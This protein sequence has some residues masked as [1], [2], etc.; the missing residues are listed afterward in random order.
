LQNPDDLIADGQT[1]R[2][3]T[4]PAGQ[5]VLTLP[6][7]TASAD[8]TSELLEKFK[9]EIIATA[10]Y[11]TTNNGDVDLKDKV[12][13]LDGWHKIEP[14]I[15]DNITL[16]GP[17]NNVSF[18]ND[19]PLE[20]VDINDIAQGECGDCYFLA[21]IGAMALKMPE[22]IRNDI[23]EIIPDGTL[24]VS[25]FPTLNG[26]ATDVIIPMTLDNGWAQADLSG[27][28]AATGVYEV[29]TIMLEK[30][31]GQFIGCNNLCNGGH[32]DQVWEHILNTDAARHDTDANTNQQLEDIVR[33]ASAA[34]KMMVIGTRDLSGNGKKDEWTLSNGEKLVGNHAFIVKEIVGN[35]IVLINP[36]GGALHDPTKWTKLPFSDLK[37]VASLIYVE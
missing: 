7:L 11:N 14:V 19:S 24:S 16:F 23:F 30:A 9:V 20:P 37:T 1:Q 22:L 8:N 10:N 29:W 31:Y 18:L 32:A 35:E 21:A 34:N 4:I 2:T 15:M 3:V 27:D 26:P 17:N 33:N 25:F 36:W 6:A 5:D 12:P 13:G 28:T